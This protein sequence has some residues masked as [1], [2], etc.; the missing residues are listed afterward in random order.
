MIA[1]TVTGCHAIAIRRIRIVSRARWTMNVVLR[2]GSFQTSDA[3]NKIC[4][5]QSS[6]TAVYTVRCSIRFCMQNHLAY[7]V[8]RSEAFDTKSFVAAMMAHRV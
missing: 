4:G 5:L 6:Q 8:R 3:N 2:V 1:P 7:A